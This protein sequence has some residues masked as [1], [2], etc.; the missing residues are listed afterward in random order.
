MGSIGT[1]EC[2]WR[3]RN[4]KT[5]GGR[6]DKEDKSVEVSQGLMGTGDGRPTESTKLMSSGHSAS[7]RSAQGHQ[8]MLASPAGCVPW[9]APRR[10]V[11]A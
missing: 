1:C 7:T 2:S 10:L 9:S 3:N 4:Q 5:R 6:E 11:D 8:H